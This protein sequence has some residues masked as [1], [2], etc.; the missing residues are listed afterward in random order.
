MARKNFEKREDT[1]QSVS[2]EESAEIKEEQKNEDSLSQLI[3]DFGYY[4]ELKKQNGKIAEDLNN[5]IKEEFSNQNITDYEG[6]KYSAKISVQTS[7]KFDEEKLL[8]IVDSLPDD[9]RSRL[10]MTKRVVDIDLLERMITNN[11]IQANIFQPA[12]VT[13]RVT[14]LLCNKIK[15]GNK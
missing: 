15:K 3:D 5:K 2:A 14:K 13:N 4:N 12:Q 9:Y 1:E 7:I 6:E 10:V 8:Q 11:E